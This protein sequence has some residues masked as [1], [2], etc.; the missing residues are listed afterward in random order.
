VASNVDQ[1]VVAANDESPNTG[2]S[3]GNRPRQWPFLMALALLA[4]VAITVVLA[5]R[6][7]WMAPATLDPIY[8]LLQRREW[9]QAERQLRRYLDVH[10]ESP[11]TLLLSGQILGAKGNYVECATRLE[12]MN[13][14]VPQRV[15]A[16]LFAGRAWLQ[17]GRRR[18]AERVWRECLAQSNSELET[19]VLQQQ[20]RRMLCG[21]YAME[22][23]RTEL[24]ALTAEMSQFGPPRL[25]HEPLAMRARFEFEMV[26]PQVALAE[27][28]PAIAQDPQDFE[29]L[30]AAGLYHLEAGDSDKARAYIYRC[31]QENRESVPALEAWLQCLYQTADN[32]GLQQAVRELPND[33]D[34]SA[35]IWKFR[36]IAAERDDDMPQAIA[37]VRRAVAIR[38]FEAELH[39]RLGQ[40]LLRT[41]EKEEGQAQLTRNTELQNSQQ[42]LRDAYDAYRRDYAQATSEQRTNI[43]L[44]LA[45]SYEAL[46]HLATALAWYRVALSENPSHVQSMS[47]VE[48]LV[49][50]TASEP[51][52]DQ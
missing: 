6:K 44:R 16:L 35:E 23:R 2:A 14:Q 12:Q 30:R 31:V 5:T 43:V 3:T 42:N 25:R 38:P 22:R 49:S 13:P 10:P 28:E 17:A 39:H 8:L 27:L 1:T 36:A 18:E 41:G 9:S 29:A 46:G 40:Y 51:V 34:S 4:T 19:P 15:Q 37:A 7:K 48:R 26:D 52:S 21:I 50:G 11:E 33:A 45:E 32:F 24:W 20:C 47:A